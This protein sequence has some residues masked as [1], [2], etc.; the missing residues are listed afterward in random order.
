MTVFRCGIAFNRFTVLF[1]GIMNFKYASLL[2]ASVLLLVGCGKSD[3]TA[4]TAPAAAA[5]PAAPSASS[6][7]TVEVT[8]NDSMKFNLNRIEAKAGQEIKIILTNTGTMPKTAMGHNFIVL[9]KDA[10]LKVFTDA[11]V[12]A[13][14]TDYI[15]ASMADKIIAHTK[16]LGAKQSDEI[17]FKLTEAGEYPFLCSFPAHYLVGMKGVIVV[18]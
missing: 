6:V 7:L 18:Q 12:A 9:K 5:A 8:A 4:A 1:L 10:D 16:L 2:I 15:P 14:A 17:T 11:A 3:N 13:A